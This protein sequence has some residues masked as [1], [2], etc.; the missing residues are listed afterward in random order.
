MYSKI[1]QWLMVDVWR[2]PLGDQ[3]RRKAVG[4]S[5]VRIILASARHFASNK[6]QLKASALTYFTLIAIVPV[7]AA[8]I[9]VAAGFGLAQAVEMEL[10]TRFEEQQEVLTQALQFAHTLLDNVRGGVFAGVALSLL[11]WSVVKVLSHVERAFN[12]IWNVARGRTLVRRVIDYIAMIMVLPIFFTVAGALTVMLA[13]AGGHPMATL[14]PYLLAWTLFTILYLFMP[15]TR[16][17]FLPALFGGV[18]AGTAYQVVQWGYIEFQVGVSTYSAIYGSFAALPLFLMWVQIS[19]LIVLAGAEVAYATQHVHNWEY[20]DDVAAV[21]ASFERLSCLLVTHHCAVAHVK[22][23]G[24]VPMDTIA[25]VLGM[26]IT[27]VERSAK[28]LIAAAI[29]DEVAVSATKDRGLILTTEVSTLRV[30]D[31]FNALDNCGVAAIPLKHNAP[32]QAA[33]ATLQ[34]FE[35]HL[36]ALPSNILVVDLSNTQ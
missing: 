26:P 11:L 20:R 6:N 8:A 5:L 22:G 16:V 3:S 19:W 24:A 33:T 1:R 9:G 23:L 18:I 27:L 28:R 32:Y 4:I 7:L 15:H 10:L 25:D 13:S 36:A 12:S 34:A 21:S 29:V 30:T 14:A 2:I 17:R 35:K 31:L